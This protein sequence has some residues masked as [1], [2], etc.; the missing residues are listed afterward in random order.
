MQVL[1]CAYEIV[2]VTLPAGETPIGQIQ[3][4]LQFEVPDGMRLHSITQVK[5]AMIVGGNN[6]FLL[7]MERA[8]TF[9]AEETPHLQ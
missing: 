4:V 8:I 9:T 7:V 2:R 5:E 1:K 6:T 3:N